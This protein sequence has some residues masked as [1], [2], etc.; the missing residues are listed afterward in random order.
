MT[1]REKVIIG[2]M[3]SVTIFGAYSFLSSSS[4]NTAANSE[5][6]IVELN[7]SIVD[8]AG[9]INRNDRSSIEYI[10]QKAK[11]RWKKD[12]FVESIGGFDDLKKEDGY[13]QAADGPT[14]ILF[15]GFIHVGDKMIAIING[16]EY[17]EGDV[18]GNGSLSVQK[19]SRG[20]VVLHSESGE[21]LVVFIEK[22]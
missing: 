3:L 12:P 22:Y 8:L 7:K 11:E 21:D 5:K 16:L 2:L 19:I 6:V 15:T 10:L 13:K 9:K 1:K 20:K 4:E 17:E 18:I 14:S